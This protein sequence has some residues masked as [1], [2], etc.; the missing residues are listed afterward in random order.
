MMVSKTS[1]RKVWREVNVLVSTMSYMLYSYVLSYLS[2][3]AF[4]VNF[5]QYQT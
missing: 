5:T 2:V 3:E 1:N 4:Y